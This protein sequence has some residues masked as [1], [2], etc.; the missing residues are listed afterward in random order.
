LIDVLE[1]FLLSNFVEQIASIETTLEE[2]YFVSNTKAMDY[3]FFNFNGSCCSQT[4][5][6]NFWESLFKLVEVKIIFTEVLSPMRNTMD[7]IYDEPVYLLDSV[8]IIESC[9]KC[10]TFYQLFWC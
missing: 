3:V 10:W 7:F 2:N 1:L 8:E 5:Q 4:K 9:H 6:W